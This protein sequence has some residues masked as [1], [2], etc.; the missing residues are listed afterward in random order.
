MLTQRHAIASLINCGIML[1]LAAWQLQRAWHKYEL[2]PQQAQATITEK[3]LLDYPPTATT[4]PIHYHGSLDTQRYF[5]ITPAFKNHMVGVELLGIATTK[6]MPTPVIIHLGWYAHTQA[7]QQALL[8]H[9]R[10]QTQSGLLYQPKGR[11]ISQH[12]H[13]TGWP[14]KLSYIDIDSI[15][16]A[17]NTSVFHAVIV[18]PN[19]TLYEKLINHQG[20]TLG[21]GRHIC[22]A[23]QFI[24]FGIIGC[25]LSRHLARKTHEKNT[26]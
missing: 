4:T 26:T 23:L 19:A 13:H 9:S 10:Q 14:Q 3:A 1:L 25:L 18:T 20:L 15:E 16:K 7:A 17:L 11:L 6:N 12:A 8:K 21:I 22:Y 5:L 2:I 24:A